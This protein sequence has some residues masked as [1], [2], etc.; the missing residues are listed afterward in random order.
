MGESR[1]ERWPYL[2]LWALLAG[3]QG[4]VLYAFL[5]TSVALAFGVVLLLQLAKLPVAAAR[6]RALGN[7]AD[8]ALMALVPLANIGLWQRLLAAD[9]T[10]AARD[11]IRAQWAD[12]LTATQAF[13]RGARGLLASPSASLPLALGFGLLYAAGELAV[14]DGLLAAS[15]L[16][17]ERRELLGQGLMVVVALLGLYTL[18]QVMKRRTATRASWM[19][20]FL[21][22]PFGLAWVATSVGGGAGPDPNS[23][24]VL[25]V[26]SSTA[27]S[28]AWACLG[29]AAVGVLWVSVADA[30]ERGQSLGLGD[31]IARVV[32][33]TPDVSAPHGA[34]ALLIQ[35]G[36]QV[37]IPG[38][39]Y[40]L[41][42]SFVDAAAVLH[43]DAPALRRSTRLTRGIR[44]RIFKVWLLGFLV[45]I[46]LGWLFA[47]PV[48]WWVHRADLSIG[49]IAGMVL[50]GVPTLLILAPLRLTELSGG[51]LGAVMVAMGL[52]GGASRVAL[53]HMYRQRLGRESSAAGDAPITAAD[54]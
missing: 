45:A 40:A 18:V 42:F 21:L 26:L 12:E 33:R 11:A 46:V 36:L 8:D 10:P 28:L 9:P 29:G 24:M 34:A 50:R 48:E 38:I 3:A 14:V 2:G 22:L 5:T 16:P 51:T 54:A 7:P 47:F 32:Q 39:I 37:V 19:P 25:L 31:A 27:W 52:G 15:Q 30:Q 23:G 20:T 13:A 53:A 4:G 43:R 1:L 41:Q 6:L 49:E 17:A 35:V 44:R